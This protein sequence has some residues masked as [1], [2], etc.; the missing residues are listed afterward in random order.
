MR[1]TVKETSNKVLASPIKS[2]LVGSFK[3]KLM[4]KKRTYAETI[5]QYYQPSPFKDKS[6]NEN[7]IQRHGLIE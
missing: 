4:F 3:P 1:L 6:S 7:L 5:E 2:K